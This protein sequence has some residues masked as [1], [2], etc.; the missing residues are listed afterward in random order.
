MGL[1]EFLTLTQ[2]TL[3]K[4]MKGRLLTWWRGVLL[5]PLSL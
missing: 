2:E 4:N 1:S 3:E 5:L